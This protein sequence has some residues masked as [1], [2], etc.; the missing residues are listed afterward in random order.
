LTDSASVFFKNPDGIIETPIG[1]FRSGLTSFQSYWQTSSL[2]SNIVTASV[3]SKIIDGIKL[4]YGLRASTSSFAVIEPKNQFKITVGGKNTEFSLNF[5]SFSESDIVNLTPQLDVYISGSEIVTEPIQENINLSP[6]QSSSFGTYIGSIS[7]NFGK[8]RKNSLTFVARTSGNILPKFVSRVG[9][10]HLGNIELSPT[11]ENG[12]NCNQTKIYAPMSLPTGSEVNFKIDYLNPIGRKNSNYSTFIKGVYFQGSTILGNTIIP[13]GTVSGSDQ[14]TSSYDGRYERKGTNIFSSSLQVDYNQ[15]QNK[16]NLVSPGANRIF[17]SDGTVS[18]SLANKDLLYI[19]SSVINRTRLNNSV[20]LERTISS[21]FWSSN[22]DY[23][24]QSFFQFGVGANIFFM[25]HHIF[26]DNDAFGTITSSA[27]NASYAVRFETQIYGYTGSLANPKNAY[28]WATTTEVKAM[29]NPNFGS[30]PIFSG[31]VTVNDSANSYG[32]FG[33]TFA[34]RADLSSWLST[35]TVTFT[36]PDYISIRFA[37][38]PTG[39]GPT[40]WNF[41]I[42]SLCRVIKNEIKNI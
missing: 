33:Q 21:S 2:G 20:E 27:Y 6:I 34:G 3:S 16:V 8:L 22:T 39:S 38:S 10:W 28:M 42:N 41:H 29:L 31:L 1:N 32:S 23:T 15:I 35:S 24:T 25:H 40:L 11:D 9:N 36:S 12:F 18:G 30:T 26:K 7:Q 37:L 17:T 13:Q 4:D 19:S 5:D 14:L